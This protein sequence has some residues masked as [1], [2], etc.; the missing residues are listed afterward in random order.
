VIK[1]RKEINQ[2]MSKIR[3]V[4]MVL[5]AV[6][7]LSALS[8]SSASAGWL[9]NGTSLGD[10]SAALSTQALV[11]QESTLLVPTLNLAIKCNGH[12]LDELKPQIFGLDRGFAA[13]LTFLGCNTVTPAGCE[14]EEK[15]QPI[16]TTAILT[17]AVKGTKESVNITFKPEIGTTFTNI[18][19]S[20]ANE[21]AFNGVEPV[22][23]SFVD[24]VPTGQLSLLAQPLVGLG[25]TEGNNSLLVAGH[26]VLLDGGS[27]LLTLASD[28]KWSFD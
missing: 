19:F 22:T 3:V 26:S 14:L 4:M 15:N 18:K 28:S 6:A 16:E 11:D 8:A 7:A 27:A 23:G 1:T 25:S 5:G 20:E 12:F 13:A 9:I 2:V 10:G 21:C 24:G 17:L